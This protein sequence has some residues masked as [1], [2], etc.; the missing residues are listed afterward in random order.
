MKKIKLG[1]VAEM[2]SNSY[3]ETN[4]DWEFVN[5]LDT[6]SIT[7]NEM[8]EIQLINLESEKLPDR[9]KRKVNFNSI[10]YSTV[11]P[12]QKHFGI[13][14]HQPQNFLVSTGFTVINVKPEKVDANFLYYQL[15]REEIIKYLQSI[16]EQSTTAYPSIKSSDIGNLEIELP[17]LETQKQIGNFLYSLDEKISINKKIN[18]TLEDMA[19]TLYLHLFF[20]R[21]PNGKLRDLITENT[22]STIPVGDAKDSGGNFPFFTSGENILRWNE[23]LVDG[24]NIFMNTGGNAGINF[25]IGKAAYS[26]DTW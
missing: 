15:T 11:R 9:A 25:Y 8:A 12:N 10:I 5:Y 7:Q 16:A 24:R 26:T 18:A 1:D 3:S 4:D 2:N 13:I 23:Y 21:S 22:K 17:P 19:K 6:S 14:K 20:R